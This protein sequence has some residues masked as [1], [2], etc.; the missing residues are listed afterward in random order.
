MQPNI[1]T[2]YNLEEIWGGKP[3]RVRLGAPAGKAAA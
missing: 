3:I 1:R 2:Y